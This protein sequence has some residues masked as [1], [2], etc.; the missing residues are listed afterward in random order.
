VPDRKSFPSARQF[1]SWAGV[2]PG[3]NHSADKKHGSRTT[4]GNPWLRSALTECAWAVAAGKN[5]FLKEKF[6]RIASKSSGKK[7]AA[8]MAV[9]HNVLVLIYGVLQTL[10]PYQEQ[11]LPAMS[12]EQKQRLIR[13]HFRRLGRLGVAIPRYL[14][15]PANSPHA[16]RPK[17]VENK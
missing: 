16:C 8:L 2:C 17:D 11:N 15:A 14:A 1:S 12:D 4:G 9:A 10:E 3:N 5:C 13:H 7:K 6:W